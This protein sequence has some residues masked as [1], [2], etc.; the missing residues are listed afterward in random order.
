MAADPSNLS[1]LRLGEEQREIEEKLQLA[2]L[3][4]RFV[5]YQRTS[6]RPADISQAM[7]D[8]QPQIVHFSGHSTSTGALCFES[9]SGD[10]QI[11]QPNAIAS[12]FEQFAHIVDCV[13]LNACYSKIQANAI[14]E[15]I[16]FVVGMNKTVGDPAAIAFSVGFYQALGSGSEIEEAYRLGCVQIGLQGI[17]EHLTPVLVKKEQAEL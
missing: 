15:H 10:A 8:V 6:V 7:L 2:K 9:K 17:P 16:D 11:I 14:A 1:R 13:V 4:E 12:L 5:L 3:R